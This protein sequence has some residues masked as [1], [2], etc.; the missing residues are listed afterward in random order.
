MKKKKW[1]CRELP[2][3][4]KIAFHKVGD[5]V[6]PTDLPI[7]RVK[8]SSDPYDISVTV[9]G[10]VVTVTG[11]PKEVFAPSITGRKQKD[12]QLELSYTFLPLAGEEYLDEIVDGIQKA[13]VTTA[14]L[15]NNIQDLVKENQTS[16]GN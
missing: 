6:M 16:H 9:D 11:K 1:K 15:K 3:Q 12:S 4:P 2:A 14:W 7:R 8:Y 13:K 10:E 5:R